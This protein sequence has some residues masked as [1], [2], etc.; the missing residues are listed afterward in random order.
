MP[1]FA[2]PVVVLSLDKAP[3][4]SE[5]SSSEWFLYTGWDEISKL[6]GNGFRSKTIS[7][8]LKV[9][10]SFFVLCE[11]I[12][13]PDPLSVCY[14]EIYLL[15]AVKLI[16]FTSVSACFRCFLK[17]IRRKKAAFWNKYYILAAASLH[18]PLF[19]NWSLL[20]FRV[21]CYKALLKHCHENESFIHI[22]I[23][24][25]EAGSILYQLTPQGKVKLASFLR[26][27]PKWRTVTH[28]K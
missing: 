23:I 17:G 2:V 11:V 15:S 9:L 13:F 27:V 6:S 24:N 5:L 22:D 20:A 25:E 7:A 18:Y 28:S 19:I 4:F 12:V 21:P 1:G 26:V 10:L 14:M 8:G 16:L 3:V